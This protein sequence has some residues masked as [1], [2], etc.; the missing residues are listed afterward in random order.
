MGSVLADR[1]ARATAFSD[2]DPVLSENVWRRFRGFRVCSE[3]LSFV[4]VPPQRIAPTTAQSVWLCAV[5]NWM[6]FFGGMCI[7]SE[8]P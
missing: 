7:T 1:L 4:R 8:R 3:F 5:G 6:V 2:F